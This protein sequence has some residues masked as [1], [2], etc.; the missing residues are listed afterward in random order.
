MNWS[1]IYVILSFLANTEDSSDF[2]RDTLVEIFGEPIRNA[3]G[4]KKA[5]KKAVHR[6]KAKNLNDE[7]IMAMAMAFLD[8]LNLGAL[9]GWTKEYKGE[10]YTFHGYKWE[11]E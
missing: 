1:L 4:L 5:A 8:N 7:D 11:K 10:M 9:E 3:K 6:I 2:A